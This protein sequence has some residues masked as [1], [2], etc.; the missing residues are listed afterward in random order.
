MKMHCLPLFCSVGAVS[1][2]CCSD[3]GNGVRR[4]VFMCVQRERER[5]RERKGRDRERERRKKGERERAR[6]REG[7]ER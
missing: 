3:K 2:D 7:G 1:V 5:E 4:C 6:E